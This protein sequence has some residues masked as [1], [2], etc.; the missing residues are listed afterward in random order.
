MNYKSIPW[1][2]RTWK[3]F[4]DHSQTDQAFCLSPFRLFEFYQLRLFLSFLCLWSSHFAIFSA[5]SWILNMNCETGKVYNIFLSQEVNHY[6]PWNDTGE[7]V[8][9]EIWEI[10]QKD[11][12]ATRSNAQK[13]TKKT[14]LIKL[15]K[16]QRAWGIG[17]VR[18]GYDPKK[19]FQVRGNRGIDL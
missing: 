8:K 5:V 16:T 2:P 18:F 7:E 14:K 3:L 10:L 9:F 19:S 11:R 1:F 12:K 15:E 13:R 17:L 4:L 6:W